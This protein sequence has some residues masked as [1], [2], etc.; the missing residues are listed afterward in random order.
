M[1]LEVVHILRSDVVRSMALLRVGLPPTAASRRLLCTAISPTVCSLPPRQTSPHACCASKQG[2][3]AGVCRS[4]AMSSAAAPTSAASGSTGSGSAA[5]DSPALSDGDDRAVQL[6]RHVPSF[7]ELLDILSTASSTSAP[8]SLLPLDRVSSFLTSVYP[9][10]LSPFS[11]FPPYSPSAALSSS[12]ASSLHADWKTLLYSFASSANV[13]LN[14]GASLLVTQLRSLAAHSNTTHVLSVHSLRAFYNSERSAL[15]GCLAC[16]FR[17]QLDPSNPYQ[18]AAAAIVS[19]WV[20]EGGEARLLALLKSHCGNSEWGEAAD[21]RVRE[22]TLMLQVLFLLYYDLDADYSTLSTSS[23]PQR[24]NELLQLLADTAMLSKQASYMQLTEDGR[25]QVSWL[26]VLSTLVVLEVLMIGRLRVILD[27]PVFGLLEDAAMDEWR[28]WPTE[29]RDR[30]RQ[31][32]N[33]MM[34]DAQKELDTHIFSDDTFLAQVDGMLFANNSPLAQ[35]LIQLAWSVL[36]ALLVEYQEDLASLQALYLLSL[37]SP[38]STSP[39]LTRDH[40][41]LRLSSALSSPVSPFVAMTQQLRALI[42]HRSLPRPDEGD[43][44]VSGYKEIMHELLSALCSSSLYGVLE[45]VRSELSRMFALVME[46]DNDLSYRF[47]EQ[48]QLAALDKPLVSDAINVFPAQLTLLHLLT[49]LSGHRQPGRERVREDGLKDDEAEAA[50]GDSRAARDA[51]V[52]ASQSF[53]TLLSLQTYTTAAEPSD[54]YSSKPAAAG[55]SLVTTQQTVTADGVVIPAGVYGR[56]LHGNMMQWRVQWSGWRMLLSRLDARITQ[57]CTDG[58]SAWDEMSAILTLIAKLVSNHSE[59]FRELQLH[60]LDAVDEPIDVTSLMLRTMLLLP[61]AESWVVQKA[62]SALMDVLSATVAVLT[63][64]L[65]TDLIHFTRVFTATLSD[66]AVVSALLSSSSPLSSP[67]STQSCA[68]FLQLVQTVH[69]SIER[70]HGRYPLTSFLC[71]LAHAW[72]PHYQL[73]LLHLTRPPSIHAFPIAISAP[74]SSSTFSTFAALDVRLLLATIATSVLPSALHWRYQQPTDR[75]RVISAALKPILISIGHALSLSS[76]QVEE[77][78]A[79]AIGLRAQV[80]LWMSERGG[81]EGLLTA[82]VE[83]ATSIGALLKGRKMQEAALL[84]D[85]VLQ[86]LYVV[87]HILK[88]EKANVAANESPLSS[89]ALSASLHAA[90]LDP[91]TVQPRS[92][93]GQLLALFTSGSVQPHSALQAIV[94]LLTPTFTVDVQMTALGTLILACT[95]LSANLS[96]NLSSHLSPVLDVLRTS[97]NHL[98]HPRAPPACHE[99]VYQLMAV[100]LSTDA[101]LA[102]LLLINEPQADAGKAARG[103]PT[104]FSPITRSLIAPLQHSASMWHTS[105]P[106][107]LSSVFQLL[108]ALWSN[109]TAALQSAL[110][111]PLSEELDVWQHVRDV[112]EQPVRS[113]PVEEE[114]KMEADIK[115]DIAADSDFGAASADT[116]QRVAGGESVR[117]PP[118]AKR[119]GHQLSIRCYALQLLAMECYYGGTLSQSVSSYLSTVD[120]VALLT[121]SAQCE[122]DASLRAQCLSWAE[123]LRIDV[124]AIENPQQSVSGEEDNQG[125]YLLEVAHRLLFDDLIA[126]ARQETFVAA[127]SASP[128]PL[129]YFFHQPGAAVSSDSATSLAELSQPTLEVQRDVMMRFLA[130]LSRLNATEHITARQILLARSYHSFMQAALSKQPD[131]LLPPASPAPWLLLHALSTALS[132]PRSHTRSVAVRAVQVEVAALLSALLHHF[133]SSSSSR[134][135]H[136]MSSIVAASAAPGSTSYEQLRLSHAALCGLLESVVDC[137]MTVARSTLPLSAEQSLRSNVR[138]VYH[139]CASRDR[140][141]VGRWV[142]L[143]GYEAEKQQNELDTD[144]ATDAALSLFESLLLSASLLLR[145]SCHLLAVYSVLRS[146]PASS[147]RTTTNRSLNLSAAPSS[148]RAI[149]F[150]SP[151]PPPTAG[152]KGPSPLSTVVESADEEAESARTA[153][154][155]MYGA[156][157]SITQCLL[158]VAAAAVPHPQLG[159]A[160]V[161]LATVALQSINKS[162]AHNDQPHRSHIHA[163]AIDS[164][165]PVSQEESSADQTLHVAVRCL[166]QSGLPQ[167]IHRLMTLPTSE[168]SEA[169]SVLRLLSVVAAT[170]V[171]AHALHRH[172]ILSHLCQ[173]PVLNPPAVFASADPPPA[174]PS[175]LPSFSPYLTN[176]ERDPWHSVWCLTVGLVHYLLQSLCVSSRSPSF[177]SS[178]LQFL[179]VYRLRL[180]GVLQRRRQRSLSIGHLQE[181]EAVVRYISLTGRLLAANQPSSAQEDELLA[182]L[183]VMTSSLTDE[184]VKLLMDSRLLEQRSVPISSEE[185]AMAAEEQ[186]EEAAAEQKEKS[187]RS[188]VGESKE[189]RKGE[190]KPPEKKLWRPLGSATKK[191][192]AASLSSHASASLSSPLRS[193]GQ[194]GSAASPP[195]LRRVSGS[196]V[197]ME[198]SAERASGRK[199]PVIMTQPPALQAASFLLRSPMVA[200]M[201]RGGAGGGGGDVAADSVF[202]S[203]SSAASS[204]AAEQ[205]GLAF[206]IHA[207]EYALCRILRDAFA[208]LRVLSALNVSQPASHSL[209]NYRTTVFDAQPLVGTAALRCADESAEAEGSEAAGDCGEYD[210]LINTEEQYDTLNAAGAQI[211]AVQRHTAARSLLALSPYL[212]SLSYRPPLSVLIDFSRYCLHL[213]NR[214]TAISPLLHQEAARQRVQSQLAALATPPHAALGTPTLPSMAALLS[215]LNA[216]LESSL[217]IL[218]E[219]A[220]RHISGLAALFAQFNQFAIKYRQQVRQQMQQQQQQNANRLSLPF[221]AFPL[222]YSQPPLSLPA[223]S[224]RSHR[225]HSSACGT[226]RGTGTDW[227]CSRTSSHAM[228][229][230]GVACSS[231]GG[232]VACTARSVQRAGGGSGGGGGSSGVASGSAPSWSAAA[233]VDGSVGHAPNQLMLRLKERMYEMAAELDG[234][235]R[236][237]LATQ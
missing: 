53:R 71:H 110:I 40:L 126:S 72:I 187:D 151:Q 95:P 171:G 67:P 99:L 64:S 130:A 83:A 102:E 211:R 214:L 165:T 181:V 182:E 46:G 55:W 120:S 12:R 134:S 111:R 118:S 15:L 218:V 191:G 88:L 38:L 125:R 222:A 33:E 147:S 9:S 26:Y 73:S 115:L 140:P 164:D 92:T 35:P 78:V 66:S 205:H 137:M 185:R 20:K 69:S 4:S 42:A 52:C 97:L 230:R 96:L 149:T 25:Q 217:V 192:T 173:H 91:V 103:M 85:V 138:E 28:D 216:L 234:H 215:L 148:A 70:V 167:L 68:V 59:L 183:R 194:A 106:A 94:L 189:E 131:M 41:L 27:H 32:V 210:D 121:S 2:R 50:D 7:S 172:S 170:R 204:S 127:R 90:M 198:D 224:P 74:S 233:P 176:G 132:T 155:S 175:H 159:R 56:L 13:E 104:T 179:L 161:A 87:N 213:L 36:L 160:S 22:Q 236:Q 200:G 136:L 3:T 202:D 231:R 184:Y 226:R 47:W 82:A 146:R 16:L 153:V 144:S 212:P 168:A 178:S 109:P 31:E 6:S 221:A 197:V 141:L 29:Q 166:E 57:R 24:V 162:V 196:G 227:S 76:Q 5:P 119:Y 61:S 30:R 112:L 60:A 65:Q 177:L 45:G 201:R 186:R 156:V 129:A 143:L 58:D 48:D 232:V 117:V 93:V 128:S 51:T 225:G 208:L 62:D 180:Q 116:E 133:L 43:A 54:Y 174:F 142:E 124:R 44:D 209:F 169:H 10:L 101:A 228:Y 49:A 219:Q 188:E 39:I 105:Q 1:Q 237:W 223:S 108:A 207:I 235:D 206:F 100:V 37:S 195:L 193:P 203:W 158:L 81:R 23:L 63:A 154:G 145:Y 17:I 190:E 34:T 163:T 229:P 113:P 75:L 77:A 8:S 79:G 139:H 14:A 89:A 21:Q 107:L 80:A 84:E 86:A 98:A 122:D 199:R 157:S 114:R 19:K 11:S 152:K 220:D 135:K 123:Q 18:P 150:T